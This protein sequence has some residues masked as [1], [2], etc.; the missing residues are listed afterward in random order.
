MEVEAVE[1]IYK[2]GF[3]DGEKIRNQALFRYEDKSLVIEGTQNQKKPVD[4]M[5][6]DVE[7]LLVTRCKGN[8][9]VR[10]LKDGDLPTLI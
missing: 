2:N 5:E 6:T 10:S 3:Y 1:T 8:I 4:C 7:N 9:H